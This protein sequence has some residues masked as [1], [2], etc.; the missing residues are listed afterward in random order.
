M[1]KKKWPSRRRAADRSREIW[2]AALDRRTAPRRVV[3]AGD[4]VAFGANRDLV[5]RSIEGHVN[6]TTRIGLDGK[7]RV[8]LSD[9]NAIDVMGTSPDGQWVTFGG[10][11]T[12]ERLGVMVAPVYGGEARVL[13]INGCKPDWSPDASLLYLGIGIEPP[14]PILVVPLQPGHAFPEFPVNGEDALSA[15]WKLPN[16]RMIERPASI[17]GLDESTYVVTKIEERRNLFRVPLPR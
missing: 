1:R 14:R 12:G 3:Q 15:W 9:I 4:N 7:N 16:A 10:R 5:F 6:F 11:F 17:P 2:V 8:R 13:C